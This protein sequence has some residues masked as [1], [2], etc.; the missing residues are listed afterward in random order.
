MGM[1]RR[2][3][4]G[5]RRVG[6]GLPVFIIAE[7]GVNHNGS[8]ALAR[9]MVDAA[10][11]AGADAVKFQSYKTEKIITASA[12]CAAYHLRATGGKESWF[13]LLK[14]LELTEGSQRILFN[15]CARKGIMFL[16]T[17]YDETSADFLDTLGVSAFKIASTDSNNIP[18]LRHVARFKKPIFLSTGMST[19]S[20]IVESVLAIK[21]AG[22][23]KVVLLQC[24]ANYP[25]RPEDI[26]LNVLDTFRERFKVLIGYSD[27]LAARHTAI[28]SVAKGA[29]VYEVHFTLNREMKGPDHKSSAEPDDLKNII[30]DIRFT[31]KVLGGRDK[32][33][34]PSERETRGKLRKSVIALRDIEAAELF[35]RHNIG[36]RR[37][38][39]GLEPKYFDRLLGKKPKRRILK[40]QPVMRRDVKWTPIAHAGRVL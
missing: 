33:V 25:P 2:F 11:A 36:I 22:N 9:K 8:T 5:N 20:E 6:K 1:A 21:K 3:K 30:S 35:T 31:E 34:T 18:L 14:R 32:A 40:D 24:T 26:N 27:H 4:I 37:P 10:V 12:P 15:H 17:P 38:G 16:S 7:A 28:A 19:I 13:K 39:T 29:C 23:T